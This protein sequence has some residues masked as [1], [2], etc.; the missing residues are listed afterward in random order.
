MLTVILVVHLLLTI[1]MVGLILMQKSEG[2]GLATGGGASGG[3][4]F[5]S[6]RAKGNILSRATVTL[7]ICFMV[8]SILLAVM[9]SMKTRGED[10]LLKV[11]MGNAQTANP[12]VEEPAEPV[13]PTP[14]VAPQPEASGSAPTAPAADSEPPAP[15]AK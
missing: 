10:D 11:L 5:L 1:A 3:A 6:G 8:T 15:P 12:V 4:G 9:A 2:G 7:A 13:V 14:K